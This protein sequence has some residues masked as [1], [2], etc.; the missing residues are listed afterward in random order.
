MKNARFSGKGRQSAPYV[1]VMRIRKMLI[2]YVRLDHTLYSINYG[3][4]CLRH[5]PLLLPPQGASACFLRDIP[6]SA[7]YFPLYAHMKV[8]TSRPDGTNS[9]FSLFSSGFIAGKYCYTVV[10]GFIAG[11]FA[12]LLLCIIN[13]FNR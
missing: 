9:P 12:I 7:I 1:Y 3:I 10:S 11:K 2:S 6:F 13:L 8:Y 4:L 5:C